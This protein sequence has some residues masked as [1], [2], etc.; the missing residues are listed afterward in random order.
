MFKK[1]VCEFCGKS[2]NGYVYKNY[3]PRFCSK[4]CVKK[5]LWTTD[6]FR[7]KQKQ[8]SRSNS[9]SC[10]M[11]VLWGSKKFFGMTGKYHSEE[12][13]RKIGQNH[14]PKGDF[15][16][17]NIPWNKGLTKFTDER[18]AKYGRDSG[19]SR[20]G[21]HQ[22]ESHIENMKN[23]ITGKK[24][25]QKSIA[26]YKIAAKRRC[27]ENQEYWKA[28]RKSLNLRPN[29]QE[30]KLGSILQNLLPNEYKYVGDFSFILGG[31]CPDFM[32]INGK[33]KL[34]ELYGSYW[35]RDDNPQDRINFFKQFGFDTLIVWEGELRD[36]NSLNVKLKKFHL[37]I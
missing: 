22:S 5:F 21:T 3:R 29:K 18:V 1:I 32:N 33:K 19:K 7:E 13:K 28:L 12:T 26:N 31:K 15:K 14:S 23:A 9:C 30:K 20:K 24:R 36:K 2:F 8:S 4:S 27:E 34:I 10:T 6:E 37:V 35:H 16:K 25:S 11:K 17:G